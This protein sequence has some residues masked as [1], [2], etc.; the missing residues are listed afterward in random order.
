MLQRQ[1]L[2]ILPGQFLN[3]ATVDTAGVGTQVLYGQVDTRV[4]YPD[5]PDWDRPT[6][7]S[8]IGT[9]DDGTAAFAVTAD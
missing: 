5:S 4:T 9:L 2:V 1:K 3:D 7:T 6:I 8:T